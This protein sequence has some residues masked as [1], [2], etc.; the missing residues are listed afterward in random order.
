M[1]T[2]FS[3]RG[4]IENGN[5][6]GHWDQIL[7]AKIGLSGSVS[8]PNCNC[9]VCQDFSEISLAEYIPIINPVQT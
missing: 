7:T 1:R 2:V 6:I 4:L 3:T 9:R 8:L 5:T